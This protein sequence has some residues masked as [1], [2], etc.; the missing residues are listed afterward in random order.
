[1]N[2]EF[3]N[4]EFMNDDLRFTNNELRIVN[5]ILVLLLVL[6]SDIGASS[7]VCSFTL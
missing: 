2:D 5:H 3:M 7:L 1:M 6:P 4:D